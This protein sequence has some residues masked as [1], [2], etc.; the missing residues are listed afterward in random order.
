LFVLVQKTTKEKAYKETETKIQR[1]KDTK[2]KKRYRLFVIDPK[3]A[4]SEP[5]W[6]VR[7]ENNWGLGT[8]QELK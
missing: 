2:K 1:Y 3:V 4:R 7:Y 6:S 5:V 8:F